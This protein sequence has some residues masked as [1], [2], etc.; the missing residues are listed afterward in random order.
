LL[1]AIQKASS[2]P[3]Q[4][5]QRAQII[6]QSAKRQKPGEIAPSVGLSVG[7]IRTRVKRFNSQGLLGLFDEPRSGRPREY[8]A[9]Q[10]LQ[11]TKIA[12]TPPGKLEVPINTWSLSHLRR[13]LKEKT[14]VGKLCRETIRSILNEQGISLQ[15]AQRWQDSSD[16]ELGSKT[17]AIIDGYVNPPE[18][19]ILLC[20]DQKG[21]VQFKQHG[22]RY[23]RPRKKPARVP[24]EYQRHGTG[25]LLAALNP[26]TG[27]VWGRCFSKY[28]SGT[29]IWF[30][31][32]LLRQLPDD[33]QI[34]IVWDN[35]SPHSKAVKR[36]LQ[37]HFGQRVRWLHTPKKAAW[38]NLIE[39][40]MSMFERDVM[41]NSHFESLAAFH[42]AVK[43][44]LD[45]YNAQ[46]HPFRWGRKRSKRL[47][48]VAPLRRTILWGRACG[49]ALPTRFAR[50][51]AKVVIT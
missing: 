16:P 25:Y 39:A 13:Y 20:F 36:W 8:T 7:S 11:V 10:A 2:A 21:P 27:Q 4:L 42:W 24:D 30:L 33:V 17:K 26:H 5:V 48:L 45:Y 9:E 28:N 46:C 23:Y 41:R 37:K 50:R 47:F 19:T 31:G 14:E 22:G 40:W 18:N 44:Y 34:I 6:L 1:Q 15:Q 12:T 43:S 32:W 3:V 35:A 29:V 38:L 49:A 51:L